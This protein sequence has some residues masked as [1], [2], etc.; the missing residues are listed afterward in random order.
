[1]NWASWVASW[2]CS[3]ASN[4][5]NFLPGWPNEIWGQS[6]NGGLGRCQIVAVQ[7]AIFTLTPK[8]LNCPQLIKLA[9][10]SRRRSP[11]DD[12]SL[13]ESVLAFLLMGL[14]IAE[15]ERVTILE[16]D[17][18][19]EFVRTIIDPQQLDSVFRARLALVGK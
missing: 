4:F 1:M 11:G 14:M 6:K 10:G 17:G 15:R 19:E 8:Q 9:D 2:R 18:K 12:R 5:M 16:Q 13:R 7:S 3:M